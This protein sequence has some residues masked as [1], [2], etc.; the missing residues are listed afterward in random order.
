MEENKLRTSLYYDDVR[1]PV[2]NAAGCGNWNIVRNHQEFVDYILK[3][4]IPDLIS[5]DHDISD[6]HYEDYLKYQYNGVNAINYSDF[7]EKTGLDTAKWLIEHCMD[8]N[9]E[10]KQCAVHSMNPG[11][12]LNIQ[13]LINNYKKHI[14][15]EPDCFIWHPLSK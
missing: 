14:G 2:V 3:N 8:N 12:A 11:G 5:F 7:K 6:E 9:L 13:S 15:Q 4:G 10:L 1:T